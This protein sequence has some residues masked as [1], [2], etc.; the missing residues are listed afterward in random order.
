V[1]KSGDPNAAIAFRALGFEG[2]ARHG[3]GELADALL[4][5]N[6]G[7]GGALNG[8]G[9]RGASTGG[10][11]RARQWEQVQ[12]AWRPAGWANWTETGGMGAHVDSTGCHVSLTIGVC[13]EAPRGQQD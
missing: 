4:L 8:M 13:L 11:R 12:V 5:T 7:Q 3:V 9:S 10:T 2:G 1:G 6:D